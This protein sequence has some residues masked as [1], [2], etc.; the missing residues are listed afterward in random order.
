MLWDQIVERLSLYFA[1]PA[2]AACRGWMTNRPHGRPY[3]GPLVKDFALLGAYSLVCLLLPVTGA[4]QSA[5]DGIRQW[6]RSPPRRAAVAR[7]TA[8]GR[9]RVR[10]AAPPVGEASGP[11]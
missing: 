8:R 10:T 2:N 9:G 11:R 7:C 4:G 5:T 1:P 3:S 6:F